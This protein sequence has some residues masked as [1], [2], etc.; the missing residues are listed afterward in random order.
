MR[1]KVRHS[2]SASDSWRITPADAGKSIE[3]KWQE[4]I[5]EDHPR[6][7]GE[8]CGRNSL[9]FVLRGSPPQM[10]GKVHHLRCGL[11]KM[12][13]TPADAGKRHQLLDLVKMYKD[14]PRRCGEKDEILQDFLSSKGSPP[15]MRGKV[16][17]RRQP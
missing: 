5:E 8:K 10:R 3:H 16:L 9:L 1:G 15:Q 6:R 7:C 13:I 11:L 12:R 14:H 17:Q 4:A 2:T